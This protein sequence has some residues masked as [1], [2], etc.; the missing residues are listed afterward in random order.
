MKI[1]SAAL[2]K[3]KSDYISASM[4]T[5]THPLWFSAWPFHTVFAT[6][7]ITC[8][9]YQHRMSHRSLH[10]RS[11]APHLKPRLPTTQIYVQPTLL[12]AE[13]STGYTQVYTTKPKISERKKTKNTK[14]TNK[15]TTKK[16]G[17]KNK[18]KK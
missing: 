3:H 16:I 9:F 12:N 5:D 8:T 15:N 13:S 4:T 7:V 17:G 2:H 6:P 10:D 1:Q 14:C 11:R 18:L